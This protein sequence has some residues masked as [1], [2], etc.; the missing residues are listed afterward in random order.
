MIARKLKIA[1]RALQSYRK[2]EEGAYSRGL[3]IEA[4]SEHFGIFI[5]D[6]DARK[7]AQSLPAF[8]AFVCAYTAVF[9]DAG[10]CAK[11]PK[12]FPV[13]SGWIH[14]PEL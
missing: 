2:L 6:R 8:D 3:I 4:L 9:A 14:Y 11:P 5:Y 10:L 1:P 13:P 12:G 7:L